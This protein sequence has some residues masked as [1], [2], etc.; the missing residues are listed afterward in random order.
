[1]Q[2]PARG[3]QSAGGPPTHCLEQIHALVPKLP[4][5]DFLKAVRN[6]HA[7]RVAYEESFVSSCLVRAR[8]RTRAKTPSKQC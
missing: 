7:T 5:K 1:V 2:A 8:E 3:L 4:E 6:V